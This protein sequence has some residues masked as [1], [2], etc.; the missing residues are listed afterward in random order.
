MT[1]TTTAAQR[2]NARMDKIWET[3]RRLK[4]ERDAALAAA[5]LLAALELA[6]DILPAVHPESDDARKY[7]TIRAAIAAAADNVKK[8]N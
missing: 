5:N 1:N 2:Y 4:A 7:E 3:A 8:G 6:W